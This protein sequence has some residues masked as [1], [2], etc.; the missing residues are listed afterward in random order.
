MSPFSGLLSPFSCVFPP[1]LLRSFAPF[2]VRC[3]VAGCDDGGLQRCCGK[4]SE[5]C[6]MAS[7]RWT[8]KCVIWSGRRRSLRWRSK[9][10]QRKATE[11]PPPASCVRRASRAVTF[12]PSS[13]C[14]PSHCRHCVCCVCVC[15]RACNGRTIQ[16][17]TSTRHTIHTVALRRP[18]IWYSSG[19]RRAG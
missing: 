19:H 16:A 10:W 6:E 5:S 13:F 9:H 15:V 1:P 17:N 4:Q 11:G 12:A 7:V 8:E 14:M 2:C 3:V 18:R